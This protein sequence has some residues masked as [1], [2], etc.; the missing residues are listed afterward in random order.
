MDLFELT[1]Q[2]VK[3]AEI[4]QDRNKRAVKKVRIIEPKTARGAYKPDLRSIMFKFE[5]E[6]ASPPAISSAREMRKE[7]R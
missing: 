5:K 1:L 3:P 2:Q 4:V 7:K 6:V